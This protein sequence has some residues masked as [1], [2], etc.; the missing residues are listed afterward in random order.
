MRSRVEWVVLG[1]EVGLGFFEE[2]LYEMT[3]QQT[4]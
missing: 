1:F 4:S 2:G 3:I